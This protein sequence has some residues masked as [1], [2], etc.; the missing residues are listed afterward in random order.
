MTELSQISHQLKYGDLCERVIA[1]QK[2]VRLEESAFT[3]DE[4][5]TANDRKLQRR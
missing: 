4:V 5:S 3:G 2:L 1:W